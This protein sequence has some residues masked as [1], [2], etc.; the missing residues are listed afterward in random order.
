MAVGRSCRIMGALLV[1]FAIVL[2]LLFL[3]PQPVQAEWRVD[4]VDCDVPREFSEFTPNAMAIDVQGRPHLVYGQNN[5]YHAYLNNGQWV[6]ET[7]DAQPGV[8]SA[9]AIAIDAA[10][11]IH[12]TYP[13]NT[14]VINDSKQKAVK[15]A[16]NSSGIWTVESIPVDVFGWGIA[17]FASIAVDSQKKAHIA[18]YFNYEERLDY[19]TNVT[20]QWVTQTVERVDRTGQYN[21]IAV[22]SNDRVHI[23]YMSYLD[24]NLTKL[25]YAT[26]QNGGWEI[27]TLQEGLP[28][29][30]SGRTRFTSLVLD[31]SNAPHIAYIA[32]EARYA[33]KSSG[34]WTIESIE[35]PITWNSYPSLARDLSGTLHLAFMGSSGVRYAQRNSGGWTVSNGPSGNYRML[36]LAVDSAGSAHLGS[37]YS[38][39]ANYSNSR[40]EYFTNDGGSWASSV[41]DSPASGRDTGKVPHAAID[42][43]GVAHLTYYDATA[44]AIRRADMTAGV[45]SGETVFEPASASSPL[46]DDGTIYRFSYEDRT[47]TPAAFR[48]VS[49]VPGNWASEDLP[50]SGPSPTW[51]VQSLALDLSGKTHLAYCQDNWGFETLIYA[52]NASGNWVTRSLGSSQDGCGAAITIDSSGKVHLLSHLGYSHFMPARVQYWTDVSGSLQA[53]WPTSAENE[54]MHGYIGSL[55]VDMGGSVHIAYIKADRPIHDGSHIVSYFRD[56]AYVTNASGSWVKEDVDLAPDSNAPLGGTSIALDTLGQVHIVYGDS[57]LLKYARRNNNSWSIETV[58]RGVNIGQSSLAVDA[59]GGLHVAYYDSRWDDLRYAFSPGNG[60]CSYYRDS[61]G[62]GYGILTDTVQAVCTSIPNG[63]AEQ[64]GDCDDGNPALHPGILWYKDADGDGYSDGMALLQCEQ[65]QDYKR[66][67]EVIAISGDCDDSAPAINPATVWYRDIDADGYSDGT[68]LIQC[69]RPDGY[70]LQ[71]DIISTMGDCNDADAQANPTNP[72]ACAAIKSSDGSDLDE[73]GLGDGRDEETLLQGDVS[74]EAGEYVFKRLVLQSG[75]RVTVISSASSKGLKIHASEFEIQSD[76]MLTAVGYPADMGLGAGISSDESGGG[77]GH[78]GV[79]GNANGSG[80]GTYGV[81]AKPVEPGSGG[82]SGADPGGTGGGALWIDVEGEFSNNGFVGVDGSDSEGSGGGGSGGS[83]YVLAGSITGS[84]RFSANGGSSITGGGGGGGRI[85]LYAN[86]DE[87]NGNIVA[88]GASGVESG[89]TGTIVRSTTAIASTANM[90]ATSVS[91]DINLSETIIHRRLTLHNASVTG[92]LSGQVSFAQLDAFAITTGAFAGKEIWRGT[93]SGTLGGN[94]YSGEWKG[95]AFYKASER[96]IYLKAALSGGV[97]GIAEGYLTET[98]SESGVFDRFETKWTVTRLG[99]ISTSAAMHVAGTLSAADVSTYVDTE[100]NALQITI[101]GTAAGDYAGPIQT[102]MTSVRVLSPDR[103]CFGEGFAFLSYTSSEGSGEAWAYASR[104]GNEIYE[105]TGVSDAPMRGRL[106][107]TLHESGWPEPRLLILGVERLDWALPAMPDLKISTWGPGMMSSGQTEDY[108]VEYR[109]DGLANAEN[110]VV[111]D[112]MPHVGEYVSNSPGGLYR[113]DQHEVIWKLGTVPPGTKKY[114]SVRI[115]IPFGTSTGT[116][117]E[118]AAS[119]AS[120][121]PTLSGY[122]NSNVV[123]PFDIAEYLAYEPTTI[124][125]TRELSAEELAEFRNDPTVEDLYRYALELGYVDTGMAFEDSMA[126][127]AILTYQLFLHPDD[128]EDIVALVR[129]QDADMFSAYLIEAKGGISY[130]FERQGGMSYNVNHA[131]EGSNAIGYWGSWSP[132]SPSKTSCEANCLVSKIPGL[133]I[134]YLGGKFI[135]ALSAVAGSFWSAKAF[136]NNAACMVGCRDGCFD[137]TSSGLSSGVQVCSNRCGKDSDCYKECIADEVPI[138]DAYNQF[139][140]ASFSCGL[141]CMASCQPEMEAAAK[142]LLKE[143]VKI[144]KEVPFI[145]L[146]YAYGSCHRDCILDMKKHTC[147]PGAIKYQCASSWQKLW[148]GGDV[149]GYKCDEFYVWGGVWGAPPDT[150]SE[151]CP[152]GTTCKEVTPYA[153]SKDELCKSE[154]DVPEKAVA[155]IVTTVAHDPNYKARI[156]IDTGENLPAGECANAGEEIKYR[157]EFE[158]EGEGIAFGV[159]VTDVL[160]PAL[161]PLEIGPMYRVCK[162][163]D[164]ACVPD[165]EISDPGAYDAATRTITWTLWNEGRVNSKQ[166]GYANILARIAEGTLDGVQIPNYAT[167]YFASVP[168]VTRTNAVV[169]IVGAKPVWYKDEDGDGFGNP[170]I[171]VETCAQPEGYV[172]N[173]DDCDDGNHALNP[174]T[175]WFADQDFDG[176]SDGSTVTACEKAEGY[177]MGEELAAAYGDC[178]DANSAMNPGAIEICGDSLDNN[179]DG[180][181]DEGCSAAQDCVVSGWSTW[182]GCSAECGG[183]EQSRTRTVLT[184]ASNGGAECPILIENQ[185]CNTLSCGQTWYRDA[186]GDSY[187]DGSTLTQIDRPAGYFLATELAATT[188]DCSDTAAAVHPGAMEVCDGLDNNCNSQVDE[189]VQSTFYRDADSDG[190]GNVS[191]TTEACSAPSGYV[192]NSSDCSDT[193]AAVHPGAMEVCDG[194]DNNCNSQVDEG[195]QST[196]YRDADSDGYGNVSVTTEACS[197]PSGYVTNSSDCSDT[198]AAVH[199]GAMEVCDGLDNNC[200]S[201][202]DEGVQS[203]FYRDA[204]SDGYG[205]VSVTTEACSAPSGYV[206]NSSDCSDTAAAVH[207]GAMEVCDGLDNNCNSQVDEGVQSTFYRDADSDGYGNVSVT[208]PACSAPSGYVTNSSDCSDTAAAVHPG[209]T[210]IPDGID[211]DCNGLLDEKSCST[212]VT[213]RLSV[214]RGPYIAGKSNRR[215]EQTL[216]IRNNGGAIV[217]PI[218]LIL[219]NLTNFVRLYSVTGAAELGTEHKDQVIWINVG[220]DSLFSKNETITVTL[221][222]DNPARRAISYRNRILAG[223]GS[224]CGV[225]SQWNWP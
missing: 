176:Y 9:A 92:A 218:R 175:V 77:G 186:D 76:A 142:S 12:V 222:F 21:D 203:T 100:L 26:N 24:Y 6:I 152:K 116:Q 124:Q 89:K 41:V 200:N 165:E 212:N 167:V 14:G 155:P 13:D 42:S 157:V 71:P 80:G 223:S 88:N 58:D 66:F 147:E 220:S 31:N 158:N 5:L 39:S 19:L 109:N 188:G 198:A 11:G 53:V 112:R 29:S 213:S 128:H 103:P 10:G 48:Y 197:A 97:S 202:V 221:I 210:E 133:A 3:L 208:T 131:E 143:A 148:M 123:A 34:S 16:T 96:K 81:A 35:G 139:A 187:S 22:D 17:T 173:G 40:I 33:T 79:G 105:L 45:W 150:W 63:Y 199:P 120:T 130:I 168:E 15:Y 156:N 4:C 209:A 65:P 23:S 117:L 2:A 127:G 85:A 225:P 196:F 122:Q 64:A 86:T 136:L 172:N 146:L 83:L 224:L 93:W 82:G 194:L 56:L 154:E 50:S 135:K 182:S 54:G 138:V 51:P 170:N 18:Y 217:G 184:P 37:L 140:G 75:A 132:H 28:G 195:V 174:D 107:G 25:K 36:A 161:E 44:Q 1:S 95:V 69:S 94:L 144:A 181:V 115:K 163:E 169:T 70:R 87:Y 149:M 178:N 7:V 214:T 111:V 106:T 20:G 110:V 119:I 98:A 219:S 126:S 99:D 205:N 27:T 183:G 193:A 55:T 91:S 52:T 114:L 134:D 30:A 73:D 108:I 47:T 216:T 207:P 68:S 61:D 113:W 121:T 102:V 190:Y 57:S 90:H 84:G 192:T 101:Q 179:C 164:S 166:G 8:G 104:A 215:Y 141:S 72:A 211:N 201:Q 189:G 180:N 153:T 204:D 49:G 46:I 159:Y 78:G 145:D 185:A 62:D 137:N 32:G 60:I 206:T 43:P 177:S 191:V 118:N 160:E 151:N 67:S 74:L 129:A 59:E 125:S 171:P 162:P 38:T